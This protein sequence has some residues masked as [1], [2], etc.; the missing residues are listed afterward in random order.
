MTRYHILLLALFCSPLVG[1][2]QHVE[3]TNY[4]V[5]VIKPENQP[6]VDSVRS[7]WNLQHPGERVFDTFPI[8]NAYQ[9]GSAVAMPNAYQG[10]NCVPMPNVY[11][12]NPAE[13]IITVKSDR[14]SDFK[15]DSL[16]QRELDKLRDTLEKRKPKE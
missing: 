2:A 12:D 15:P 6:L 8:P 4:G 5:R 16:L 7:K 11:Q 3:A 13:R 1:L 10:D 14:L 9:T